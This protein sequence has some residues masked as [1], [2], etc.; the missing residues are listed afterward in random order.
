MN[1]NVYRVYSGNLYSLREQIAKLNKKAI[2]LGC[3]LIVFNE[4]GRTEDIQIKDD[5]SGLVVRVD[6]YHFVEVSG[7]APKFN[8]W[9]L[10]AVVEHTEEG[11]ILR[12]APGIEAELGEFR[13]GAQHCDHCKQAR[14]RIETFIVLHDDGSR[15]MVG[16]N[17]LRD[18]LG[19][20]SPERLAAMAELAFSLREAC[21]I[22]EGLGGYGCGRSLCHVESFLAYAAC[23]IRFFGFIGSKK[24]QETLGIATKDRASDWMHPAKDW[25]LGVDYHRPEDCDIILASKAK[26]YV[27]ETLENKD[28]E[29]ITDFEHSLLVVCKCEAVEWKNTGILAFVPEFYARSIE[30]ARIAATQNYFG[31][32]GKRV[33]N[34]PIT[35]LK[36]TGFDSAYGYT[37][38][39]SFSAN[40]GSRLIWK[41]GTNVNVPMG[42]MVNATF[43]VK[44]HEEW[45][46]NKQTKVSR[47]VINS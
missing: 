17:C 13:T 30:R 12:K 27:I 31:L 10:A 44:A 21:E 36:S 6:R 38:I 29:A 40:D 41:S 22:S 20:N 5:I 35:Y 45:K 26:E 43:T 15:K 1:S 33:K 4:T 37:Y 3:P 28:S 46:G 9:T 19:H 2:K 23:V 24:A 42:T 16:R 18:F 47:L 34:E 25:R 39:H 14:Y 8:G 11:N 7:E 32:V